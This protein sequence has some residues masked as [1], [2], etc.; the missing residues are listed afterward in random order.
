MTCPYT[1]NK[2]PVSV[3]K[4]RESCQGQ[5]SVLQTA[6]RNRHGK[7]C[8][9]MGKDSARKSLCRNSS[10]KNKHLLWPCCPARKKS[11]AWG[12]STLLHP[13]LDQETTLSPFKHQDNPQATTSTL[14]IA[15]GGRRALEKNTQISS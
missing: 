5:P 11:P 15:T 10:S 1:E 6:P 7:A 12:W 3:Q 8:G 13:E 4:S 14:P 9:D 2:I